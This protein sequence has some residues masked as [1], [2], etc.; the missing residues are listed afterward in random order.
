MPCLTH[1]TQCNKDKI[2]N[3]I[4]EVKVKINFILKIEGCLIISLVIDTP[5][6]RK[7]II[8]QP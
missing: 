2:Y 4:Q 1:A 8:G 7:F 6:F 3:I 5:V